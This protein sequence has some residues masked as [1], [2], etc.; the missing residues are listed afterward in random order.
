[1]KKEE[2]IKKLQTLKPLYEQEGFIIL[3]LFGSYARDEASENSDIDILID[4]KQEFLDKYRGFRAF[5]RFDE[6]KDEL[7]Q[8]FKAD[9]DFVDKQGLLQRN[10][11]YI[12]DR[13][14]YV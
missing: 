3:G 2:I 8:A 9:I 5:T 6:I 12:L 14:I 4:T 13:A 7:K 10:N 1:M 11:K